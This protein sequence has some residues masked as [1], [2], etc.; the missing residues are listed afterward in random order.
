MHSATELTRDSF[1]ITIEGRQAE[2]ALLEAIN[3]RGITRLVI[4]NGAAGQP[5]LSRHTRES[6]ESRI[7]T[8]LAYGD[9]PGGDVEIRGN[10]VTES[11]VDDVLDASTMV[12]AEVHE[13][14]RAA[15]RDGPPNETYRRVTLEQ[16]F[17]LLAATP[18]SP[19]RVRRLYG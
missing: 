8:A 13:S 18:I 11:C 9:L 1:T 14:V 12:P 4:E 16:A 10:A 17:D 19:S 7:V 15:R 3:D 2:E 6:A 5:E